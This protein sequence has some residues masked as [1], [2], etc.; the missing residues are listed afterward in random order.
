MNSSHQPKQSS[1]SPRL[2]LLYFVDS[3]ETR[4]VSI[5]TSAL[6]LSLIVII[7]M[8]LFSLTCNAVLFFGVRHLLFAQN[9]TRQLK[10]AHIAQSIVHEN[11]LREGPFV[12][13]TGD[14][15]LL[16]LTTKR[17]AEALVYKTPVRFEDPVTGLERKQTTT[18]ATNPEQDGSTD[19]AA[20]ASLD[21]ALDQK[22]LPLDDTREASDTGPTP[23]EITRVTHEHKASE[24]KLYIRFTLKNIAQFGTRISGH[25]CAMITAVDTNGKRVQLPYPTTFSDQPDGPLHC[26]SGLKVNFARYKPTQMVI[27]SPPMA[28]K[29]LAVYFSDENGTTEH[30]FTLSK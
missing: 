1:R 10:A 4:S 23:V 15:E 3:S 28:W 25:L 29:N 21:D 26:E 6:K 7:G 16:N 22:T 14:S 27:N 13:A 11:L 24:N 30:S 9:E 12:V 17:I 8:A 19:P 18:P 20:I 5:S 2:H